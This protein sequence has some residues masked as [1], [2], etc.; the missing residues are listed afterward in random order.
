MPRKAVE[1]VIVF[2]PDVRKRHYHESEKENVI[3]FAVQM[4]IKVKNRWMPV[5]C[6][7]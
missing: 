4:E 1:F 6:M 3:Y 2:D 5:I 7:I